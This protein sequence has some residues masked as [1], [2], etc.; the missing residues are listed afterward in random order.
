MSSQVL[1]KNQEDIVRTAVLKACSD[2]TFY[3]GEL[4]R[5]ELRH[6]GDPD[7]NVSKYATNFQTI[8]PANN[9]SPL[10]KPL[11]KNDG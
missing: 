1:S 10:S 8:V 3:E 7:E 6:D 11:S 2:V 4:R 9:K 5:P